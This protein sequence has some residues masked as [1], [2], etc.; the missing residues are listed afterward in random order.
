M[1]KIGL[2]HSIDCLGDQFLE[3][4]KG[5][6]FLVLSPKFEANLRIDDLRFA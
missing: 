2:D 6:L 4:G 1:D 5:V 3:E